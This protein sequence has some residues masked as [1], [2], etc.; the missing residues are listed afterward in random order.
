M[1]AFK[2]VLGKPFRVLIMTR[3]VASLVEKPLMPSIPGTCPAAMLMADPVMKAASETT[4]ISSTIQP[5][6]IRPMKST[7]APQITARA[8]AMT[9]GI[10]V[11]SG[12][13]AV[14]L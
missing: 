11:Y 10:S 14:T 5:H 4:G 7:I 1:A 6:R 9:Q 12:C 3:Y 2:F 8:E 13:A